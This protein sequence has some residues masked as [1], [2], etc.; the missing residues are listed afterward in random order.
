MR[1]LADQGHWGSLDVFMDYESDPAMLCE[2]LVHSNAG[3]RMVAKRQFERLM[4]QKEKACD[5]VAENE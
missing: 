5:R 1:K 4:R 3:V 2:Y